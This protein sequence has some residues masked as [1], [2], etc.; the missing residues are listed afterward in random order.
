MSIILKPELGCYIL[1][2]E[3]NTAM[4]RLL[5]GRAPCAGRAGCFVVVK[6]NDG[7]T[8]QTGVH[9]AFQIK[10]VGTEPECEVSEHHDECIIAPQ[11]LNQREGRA[12]THE[13]TGDQKQ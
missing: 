12:H 9:Q 1:G 10:D 11:T 8:E 6:G 7:A 2:V 3:K 13:S 4:L 5:T